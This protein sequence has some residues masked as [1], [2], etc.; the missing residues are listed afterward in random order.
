MKVRIVSGAPTLDLDDPELRLTPQQREAVAA[1]RELVLTAGAGAG[2]THTLSLRYTALLLELAWAGATDP[3]AVLVLTFT[4]K[5]AEEMAERCH[6][7]LIALIRAAEDVQKQLDALVDEDDESSKGAPGSRLVANLAAMADRFDRARIGT[8]HGFCASI[9]H[10][11][12]GRTGCPPGAR[13]LGEAEARH[14]RQEVLD[15]ALQEVVRGDRASLSALLDTFGSRQQLLHAGNLA[16]ARRGQLTPTLD[17]HASGRLTLQEALDAA[18]VRPAE[19]RTWI[20]K[21]GLPTLKALKR[22]VAPSGGGPFVARELE[23]AL[24]ALEPPAPDASALT[25]YGV[26]CDV[27]DVLMT[28]TG[29]V[30][31][32]DHHTV[33]GVSRAWPDERTYRVAKQALGV[34]K[35]RIADWG[36][37]A[38]QA[39]LLPTA[40]DQALYDALVPFSRWVR[41][42]AEALDQRLDVDGVLTFD[43]MLLRAVRAVLADPHLR[44]V[45][46]SRHSHIMVDEFQDTDGLQWAL[47]H[48]LGRARP[49]VAEDRLFLVGDVKQAIYGFRGGDV[50][51]FRAA[52]E[53]LRADRVRLPDNFRSQ[54]EL[55]GWFNETF[56]SVLG[57]V[58]HKPW[59]APYEALSAG[60][61]D[62]GGAVEVVRGSSDDLGPGWQSEAV[63]KLIASDWLAPGS[64]WLDR[65][66]HPAPPIAVLLR[67][68][69]RQGTYEAA[70]RRHR[71]PFVVAQGVGFWE[72]PE[73]IDIV[74]ALSAIVHSDPASIAATLRSPWLGLL[75]Q[76]LQDL[77]GG[78]WGGGGL[79][80]FGTE[81]LSGDA[82]SRLRRAFRLLASAQGLRRQVRTS[83]LVER[84]ALWQAPARAVADPSGQAD[85]NAARLVAMVAAWDGEGVHAVTDRLLGEVV[86]G[87]RESEA[88]LVA[89]AAR[90]MLCTVH[91]SK[92]LEFEGVI[93]PELDARPLNRPEP[94]LVR[95]PEHAEPDD[96]TSWRMAARVLDPTAEVQTR[97]RPGL[98]SSLDLVRVQEED[99]ESRRLLYVAATRARQRLVLVGEASKPPKPGARPTWMQLLQEALPASTVRRDPGKLVRSPAPPPV[100]PHEGLTPSVAAVS[101]I[102]GVNP[103]RRLEL[104]PSALD[105]FWACPARWYRRDLLGVPE[106][107]ATPIDRAARLAAARGQAIHQLLEDGVDHDPA[108]IEARWN[109]LATA[110]GANLAERRAGLKRL[111]AHLEA[112]R[113]DPHVRR[114]LHAPGHNEVPF[115]AEHAG[116]VLRG[117]IDRLWLDD[118]GSWVVL[119][120]KSE[121]LRGRSAEQ[122]AQSHA[123]QLLAYGWAANQVLEHRC[124][125]VISRGEVYLTQVGRAVVIG[126]WT[127]DVLD[128]VPALL[129]EIGLTAGMDWDAVQQKAIDGPMRRPCDRCGFRGRGCAGQPGTEEPADEPTAVAP[130]D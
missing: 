111:F 120:Y 19:A 44:S 14:L 121:S 25:V 56:P 82:P 83:T 4:E 74:N 91:A 129:E 79:H 92:G 86:T 80:S 48:A 40:A 29:T 107:P 17:A 125:T 31:T 15:L 59:D 102:G 45:L 32:L 70:L 35:T 30:R 16:I 78:R 73:V 36:D 69:T 124:D 54:P 118:D 93:V 1:R 49:D 37:R 21:V 95:R 34:L 71:V 127:N 42:A 114:A 26:Y 3:E 23:P 60:R 103:R 108:S 113:A 117:R 24:R 105:R 43:A 76:D 81:P 98:F 57:E 47:V 128:R 106:S 41:G 18:V 112:T 58:A 88:V 119:D 116:V 67:A 51:V 130:G 39:R 122:V 66:H 72:R 87:Q 22:L 9:L 10:E 85:A 61:T 63:A 38:V 50:T 6:R 33:M 62:T 75:D 13:V 109:A 53:S 46:R 94:L 89:S 52:S 110:Q 27:L 123:S 64:P 90:V 55:I 77:H 68:R 65:Q 97:V 96:P 100:P 126:P 2:K 8:F 104:P 84:L 101:G 7:R 11:F 20:Q 28:A 99:A 5:A 12:P 115:R